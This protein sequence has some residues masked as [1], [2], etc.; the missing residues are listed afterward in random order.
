MRIG[1]LATATSL[2]TKTIRYYESLGL[3]P[4]PSRTTAGYRVFGQGDAERLHFISKAK[5]L[6]LSLADVRDILTLH[7]QNQYPCVHV[8]A[9][10]D[11]KIAEIDALL[12]HLGDLRRE[13]RQLRAESEERLKD[14]PK[15]GS[16][17]G[18]IERGIHSRGELALVWLE[19]RT[20]TSRPGT[21]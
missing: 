2:T 9:L 8:M 16:I 12:E 15:D 11:R 5:H 18:I 4:K 19:A 3:L 21:N 7:D 20:K 10:L 14:T 17:C 1:D 6:G 13:L